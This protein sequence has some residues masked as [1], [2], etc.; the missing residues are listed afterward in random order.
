VP[1]CPYLLSCAAVKVVLV[2]PVTRLVVSSASK[3][4]D[5]LRFLVSQSTRRREKGPTGTL[6]V[7]VVARLDI[8]WREVNE[9][10]AREKLDER[11]RT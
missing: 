10:E 5:K 3:E 2:L 4:C 11:R 6:E 9:E 8:L 7:E 1:D